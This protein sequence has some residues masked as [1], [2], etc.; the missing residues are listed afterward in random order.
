MDAWVDSSEPC[1]PNG[2]A[3]FCYD[4]EGVRHQQC[5]CGEPCTEHVLPLEVPLLASFPLERKGRDI[6]NEFREQDAMTLE[7]AEAW[8]MQFPFKWRVL[9]KSDGIRFHLKCRCK[10]YFEQ[11]PCADCK[12]K[13]FKKC[14]TCGDEHKKLTLKE[15][16]CQDCV[17]KEIIFCK[18]CKNRVPRGHYECTSLADPHYSQPLGVYP[19]LHYS[20]F[21]E[22]GQCLDCGEVMNYRVYHRHQYRKHCYVKPCDLYTR[23]YIRHNCKYCDYFNFEITNTRNHQRSHFDVR[24]FECRHKCGATFTHSSSEVKHCKEAHGGEGLQSPGARYERVGDAICEM[25]Q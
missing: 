24:E 3:M 10:N 25:K 1:H 6:T 21:E 4:D 9:V 13:M 14:T 7:R 17:H 16:M 11:T 12:A 22:R 19:P 20:R 18:H 15:G 2:V 5:P 8:F 23:A